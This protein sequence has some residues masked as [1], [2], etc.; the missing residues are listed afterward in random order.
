MTNYYKALSKKE[1]ENINL[2]YKQE[3][4][5]SDLQNRL[6]R[7]FLYSLIGYGFSIF[8]IVYSFITKNDIIANLL[9]AI[10]LFVISTFFLLG[11]YYIKL[12]ILNKIVLKEKN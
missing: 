3:Y 10:P 12:K 1:K 5:K 4:K 6:F 9:I 11:R 2:L 8:L 7:L